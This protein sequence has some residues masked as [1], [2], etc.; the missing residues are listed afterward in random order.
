MLLIGSDEIWIDGG[1]CMNFVTTFL[2]GTFSSRSIAKRVQGVLQ[3]QE[4]PVVDER[5]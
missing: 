2:C 1:I 5:E 4:K 3:R